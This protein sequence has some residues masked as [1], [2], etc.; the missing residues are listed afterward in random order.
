MVNNNTH[1]HLEQN[2]KA[3]R[4]TFVILFNFKQLSVVP[5]VGTHLNTTSKHPNSK[6][7]MYLITICYYL[8]AKPVISLYNMPVGSGTS[9]RLM[10]CFCRGPFRIIFSKNIILNISNVHYCNC[11]ANFCHEIKFAK[12]EVFAW[13]ELFTWTSF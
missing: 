9:G 1:T 7:S 8:W 4:V 5:K 10:R 6:A 13:N 2:F 11:K 12:I 3:L